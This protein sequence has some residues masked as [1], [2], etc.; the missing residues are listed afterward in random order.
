MIIWIPSD[1]DIICLDET[2]EH[3]ES[4]VPNIE[5]SLLWS[6]WNKNSHYRGIGGRACYIRK[7]ISHHIQLHQID[8]LNQYIW[9]E[10]SNTNAKTMYIEICFFSPIN[11]TFYKK[12]NLDRN[13]LYNNLEQDVY[14]LKNEG[15]ILLLGNF[16]ARTVTHQ[17]NLL[18][19]DSNH[20][21]LWLDEN[22]IL[23]NSYKRS[24]EDLIENLFG[25]KLFKFC[26]SQ[27]LIIFNGVMKWSNSNQMTCIHMLGSSV[28]DYVIFDILVFNQI[29]NFDH[30]NDHEPY[31]DHRPLTL[32][33]HFAMHGSAI[34][35]NFDNQ[36][37]F[38]LTKVNLNFS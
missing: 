21:S 34:E 9:I 6:T 23:S 26:I 19:N 13:C 35:E 7:R 24:S 31:S 29:V 25:I 37:K 22:I 30:L 27:D 38:L 32:T 11:S 28:V 4:K 1:I 3:E 18:R 36:R 2:W 15:N 20:N 5:G 16:S 17:D 8:P 14:S 10:I 33:L 12:N